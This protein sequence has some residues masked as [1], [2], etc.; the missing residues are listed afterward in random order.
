[1]TR[2]ASP[3]ELLTAHLGAQ[4]GVAAG[5]AW[6]GANTVGTGQQGRAGRYGGVSFYEKL[7]VMKQVEI[8]AQRDF[9]V[10][11]RPLQTHR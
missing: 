4:G 11:R 3:V 8:C 10:I 1:M 7:R 2:A 5:A 9:L 6:S